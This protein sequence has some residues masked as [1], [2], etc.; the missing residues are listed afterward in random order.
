MDDKENNF[1]AKNTDLNKS[2]PLVDIP[3]SSEALS[4]QQPQQPVL[5]LQAQEQQPVVTSNSLEK[6]KIDN[7]SIN[8]QPTVSSPAANLTESLASP[9]SSQ[10]EPGISTVSTNEPI[11]VDKKPLASDGQSIQP[12]TVSYTQQS[13][14]PQLIDSSTGQKQVPNNPS[15][16]HKTDVLGIVSVIL[17]F[18]GITFIG[19]IVG[20]AG[21]FKAKKEGYSKTLSVIGLIINIVFAV[22]SILIF[23]V[24]FFLVMPNISKVSRDKYRAEQADL[25]IASAN[26]IKSETGQYPTS[27]EQILQ[28][29]SGRSNLD[30]PNSGGAS[31][32]VTSGEPSESNDVLLYKVPQTQDGEPNV[33]YWSESSNAT[34]QSAIGSVSI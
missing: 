3:Q 9:P 10:S 5:N 13:P 15:N 28:Y 2:E 31:A 17:A 6:P 4:N 16:A 25:V 8:Q 26:T 7:T 23:I 12:P 14:T 1:Q 11:I 18:F 34:K 24:A 19:A 22:I 20:I 29:L 33:V 30:M 32:C 21:I 27:C